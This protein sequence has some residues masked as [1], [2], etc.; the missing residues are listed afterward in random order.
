[1]D[2]SRHDE[3][4]GGAGYIGSHTGKYLANHGIEPVAYDNLSR[5][6]A[7]AVRWGPLIIGNIS[8]RDKLL[9]TMKRFRPDRLIHF[10]ER[11]N[12]FDTAGFGI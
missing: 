2:G 5:G 10:A 1:M 4:T 9:K 7:D 6:H 11:V 3:S 12:D 8:D